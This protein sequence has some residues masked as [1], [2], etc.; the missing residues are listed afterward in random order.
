MARELEID[1]YRKGAQLFFVLRGRLMLDNC[2]EAKT[3]ISNLLTPQI[4]QVYL[5]L[6]ELG[7]L[8]SAG[9]GVLVGLKMQ[10]NRNR[11]QLAL[12]APP[13]AI[14][15][16]FRV[17]K[18]DTIFELQTGAAA[19]V[20]RATLKQDEF[21][22]WRD[23]RTSR[24]A[25]FQ[26]NT[27]INLGGFAA[28]ANLTQMPA[29]EGEAAQKVRQL[30]A[31]A[32]EYIRQGDYPRAID[33]YQRALALEPDNLA[34]LNNLAIVYEKRPEWYPQAAEA[35]KKALALSQGRSDEKHAARARKHLDSLAKLTQF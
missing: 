24:P 25:A 34:A 33:A 8:D 19:D 10:A 18:L 3:R 22:L 23:G 35:W 14:A 9:L 6:G 32:V 12:L 16:I 21:C 27:E 2:Q 11:T 7:F 29:G 13:Q 26:S 31:D 4:D 1:A 20:V 5:Y 15:E 17:S 28:R 30:C